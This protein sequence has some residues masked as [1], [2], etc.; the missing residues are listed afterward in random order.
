MG[1]CLASF[2][3]HILLLIHLASF[4]LPVCKHAAVFFS[5]ALKVG[6]FLASCFEARWCSFALA[7]KA[8]F[9]FLLSALKH[10]GVLFLLL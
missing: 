9:F 6:F 5:L 4:W 10:I 3:L 1:F 2:F 8:G 7:L